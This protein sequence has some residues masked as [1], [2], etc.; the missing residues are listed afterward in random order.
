MTPEVPQ[1]IKKNICGKPIQTVSV[2][3]A[4]IIA[5]T[6]AVP[7]LQ[8]GHRKSINLIT[9]QKQVGCFNHRVV[10]LVADTLQ[11]KFGCLTTEWLPWLQETVVYFGIRG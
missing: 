9:L 10:A 2:L 1:C 7:F 3:L 5:L 6:A 11:R 8:L 4:V